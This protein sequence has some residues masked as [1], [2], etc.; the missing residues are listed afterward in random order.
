MSTTATECAGPWFLWDFNQAK[1]S[2]GVTYLPGTNG[3]HQTIGGNDLWVLLDHQDANRA[4]W[5]YAFTN[6]LTQAAQDE[7]WNLA[8]GNLPLRASE[9]DS[10]VFRDTDKALPGFAHFADN[11]VN[12]KKPRPTIKGYAALSKVYGEQ[13]AK[14]LQ[15]QATPKEGL[16]SAAASADSELADNQ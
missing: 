8:M 6:W 14:I 15:G 5:S 7:K 1:V 11:L 12:A 3:D 4:D 13:V 10:A 16:D 9:K 2:Y